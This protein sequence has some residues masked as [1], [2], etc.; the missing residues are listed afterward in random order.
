MG[1][2]VYETMWGPTEFFATGTMKD[3]DHTSRLHEIDVPTLIVTGRYDAVRPHDHAEVL[4]DRIPGAEMI[5]FDEA[6]HTAHLE[7]PELFER[8]LTDFLGR[9]DAKA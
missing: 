4:R 8:A 6:P 7:E 9:V 5:C 2:E 3:F 1:R